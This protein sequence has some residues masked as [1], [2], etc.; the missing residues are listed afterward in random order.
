MPPPDEFK[1]LVRELREIKA[2]ADA[3][4][5]R[6]DKYA[7]KLAAFKGKGK[8]DDDPPE[9]KKKGAPYGD[10]LGD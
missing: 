8:A 3:V 1:A 2:D 7:E 9:P 10:L 6:C 4:G 5:E